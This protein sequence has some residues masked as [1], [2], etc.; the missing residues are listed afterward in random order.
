MIGIIARHKVKDFSQWNRVF[1]KFVDHRK[2]AGE[3]SYTI[4]NIIG[5]KNNLCLYFEWD[6]VENANKFFHSEALTEAMKEGGV[7]E[8]PEVYVIEV[9]EQGTI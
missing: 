9:Q 8:E 6:T 3:K 5:D 1:K 2:A 4:G 7:I